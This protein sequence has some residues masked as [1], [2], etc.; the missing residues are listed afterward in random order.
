MCGVPVSFLLVAASEE[1]RAGWR[2]AID[3]RERV[4]WFQL[5]EQSVLV[6][7]R[8]FRHQMLEGDGSGHCLARPAWWSREKSCVH[9]HARMKV[10]VLRAGE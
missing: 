5:R 3:G 2:R 4:F 6:S 9:I 8:Q 7:V 10:S 1:A